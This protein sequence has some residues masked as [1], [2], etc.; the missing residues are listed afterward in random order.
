MN[1]EMLILSHSDINHPE[2]AYVLF[3]AVA[4]S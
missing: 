2:T 4:S 3:A 1:G